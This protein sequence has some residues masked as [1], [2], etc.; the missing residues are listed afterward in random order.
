[1]IDFLTTNEN[2]RVTINTHNHTNGH[3]HAPSISVYISVC[4]PEWTG[5]MEEGSSSITP[6]ICPT[7][8]MKRGETE[9]EIS[10]EN[11]GEERRGGGGVM[12]K[13][14]Q[15]KPFPHTFSQVTNSE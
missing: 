15:S 2:V 9:W 3:T 7:L 13:H 5:I 14:V 6:L 11:E 8:L 4:M 12:E 1:M 10:D